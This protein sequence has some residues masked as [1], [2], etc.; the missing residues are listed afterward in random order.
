MLLRLAVYMRMQARY[1][2]SPLVR[3]RKLLSNKSFT[4]TNGE[5]GYQVMRLFAL[6]MGH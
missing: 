2:S 5:F 4:K 6:L 3:L 1:C